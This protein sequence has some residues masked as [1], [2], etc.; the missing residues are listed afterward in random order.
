MSKFFRLS[1]SVPWDYYGAMKINPS[2]RYLVR[3]RL[4]AL[5]A[6]VAAIAAIEVGLGEHLAARIGQ[7]TALQNQEPQAPNVDISDFLAATH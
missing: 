2:A 7:T 4:I 6:F 3:I 1:A 5:V